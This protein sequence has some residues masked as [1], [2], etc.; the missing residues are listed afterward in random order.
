MMSRISSR[1]LSL[2]CGH[3]STIDGATSGPMGP[4]VGPLLSECA[5]FPCLNAVCCTPASG[6]S[7]ERTIP[8]RRPDPRKTLSFPGVCFFWRLPVR[9]SFVFSHAFCPTNCG[10][11]RFCRLQLGRAGS[12]I[13]LVKMVIVHLSVVIVLDLDGVPNPLRDNV[14]RAGTSQSFSQKLEDSE[15]ALAKLVR[16]AALMIFNPF[17]LVKKKSQE[18]SRSNDFF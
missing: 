6:T 7:R 2:K 5:L 9:V 3:A 11:W 18:L 8:K 17:V 16:P 4:L 14:S 15:S 10:R 13:E 12:G 1:A